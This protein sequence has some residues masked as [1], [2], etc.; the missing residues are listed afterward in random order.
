M[1]I[2]SLMTNIQ[3]NERS[4]KDISHRNTH[5]LELFIFIDKIV[6]VNGCVGDKTSLLA[7]GIDM[8]RTISTEI[9]SAKFESYLLG[10]SQ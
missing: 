4:K 8:T 3:I 9:F 2:S 7:L 1:L 5:L 10:S 6:D